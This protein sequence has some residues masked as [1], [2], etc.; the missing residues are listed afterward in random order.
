MKH[1]VA[2]SLSLGVLAAISLAPRM[3]EAGS[4][5]PGFFSCTLNADGSGN[6]HGTYNGARN[7]PGFN[8]QVSFAMDNSGDA[9][10]GAVYNGTSM[11][12][13]KS[14]TAGSMDALIWTAAISYRNYFYVSWDSNATCTWVYIGNMS[15]YQSVL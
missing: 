12:C 11:S 10:F 1:L 14:V 4:T 15:G 2:K 8:D 7:S 6:C 5:S 13:T 3:A 9:I